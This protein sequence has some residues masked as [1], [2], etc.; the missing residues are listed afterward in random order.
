M[1]G[2]VDLD[3][4]PAFVG[5]PCWDSWDSALLD[6]RAEGCLLAQLRREPVRGD[7]EASGDTWQR[8]SGAAVPQ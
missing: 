6:Q 5:D 3:Q 1:N 2:H 7:G 4:W 8:P